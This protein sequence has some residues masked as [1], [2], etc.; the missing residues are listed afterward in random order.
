MKVLGEWGKEWSYPFHGYTMPTSSCGSCGCLGQ[1]DPQ[2]AQPPGAPVLDPVL[3]S[4]QHPCYEQGEYHLPGEW[5]TFLQGA[6]SLTAHPLP[7]PHAQVDC[8]KKKSVLLELTAALTDGVVNG[9][10]LKMRQAFSS[11][12][13]T[14]CPSPAAKG[15][16]TQSVGC[17]QRTGWPHFQEIFMLSALSQEDVKTL[18]VS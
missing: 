15:P 3:P 5:A 8:L 11:Q 18:K 12:L 13:G 14:P 16:N 7:I 6:H 9:K 10:K 4:P 1:V 17:P 2:P